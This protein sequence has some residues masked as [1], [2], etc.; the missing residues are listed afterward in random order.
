MSTSRGG[1]SLGPNQPPLSPGVT[2]FPPFTP[3][4]SIPPGDGERVH[5]PGN[6]NRAGAPPDDGL[7]LSPEEMRAIRGCDGG[8]S[9]IVPGHPSEEDR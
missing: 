9:S 7:G 5:S 4:C 2:E 1:P 6:T 3:P 8:C